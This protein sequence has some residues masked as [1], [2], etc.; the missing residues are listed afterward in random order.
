MACTRRA[1]RI[2]DPSAPSPR[3][4]GL[5]SLGGRAATRTLE[6]TPDTFHMI[7]GKQAFFGFTV[8]PSGEVYWFANIVSADIPTRG[9]VSAI[10]PALWKERLRTLFA[11]D[12]GPA[13]GIIDATGEDLAAYPILDM[14]AVPRWHAGPMVI[15]GD[16]AH[17]T[18]PSAGQG[19][20]LA[21]ED[22]VVLARCL[23]DAGGV[24]DGFASY[25]RIRRRRVERVVRYS[26]RIGRTKVAGTDRPLV[27]RLVH[28]GRAQDLRGS[29]GARLVVSPSH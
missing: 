21:I 10:G 26:A 24:R 22:A 18:S 15:T 13:A 11:G 8:R 12:A 6:P 29:E 4:T 28:A 3:D 19:A 9:P 20:S 5:L 16:A 23:R 27:P 2:I 7:F 1:G 17:A 14:P 25:E